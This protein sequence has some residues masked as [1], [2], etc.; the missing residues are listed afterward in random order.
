MNSPYLATIDRFNSLNVMVIGDAMLDVY[1]NGSANRICREAPVPIVDIKDVRTLPGGAA[2]TAVNLAELGARVH[3]LSIMGCDHEAELLKDSL[4]SHGLDTSLIMRDRARRTITKQ[5]VAAGNQ[6]LVRFD[7]GT[8]EA[9]RGGY[10]R[11]LINSLKEKFHEVDAVVVSDYGYG[12]MTDKVIGVLGALQRKK[13]NILVIDAKSLDKY[14]RI[15][16]TVAK[17]N[18]QEL[19][20][21]LAITEPAATGY[22]SEQIK[23]YGQKLLKKTGTRYVAA[24]IDIEGALLFQH[25]KEPYRTFSKPVENTRAAGA[26]DTYVS[27]L[28]LALAAGASIEAAAE[29]AKSAAVVILQKSATATCTQNELSHYFGSSSKYIPDWKELK[30]RFDT[31]RKEGRR[32]V[33]TNGCF[34]LLHSGHVTY[35]EQARALGDVLVLGLN[36]D[37]SIKRL[38]GSNRPINNLYERIRILSGLESVTLMTSFEEDTPISL[39][40]I[41]RPD[42]YVKGGD[43]NIENLPEAPIV[44]AY[45]GKVQIMPFVQDRSTTKIITRIK[46][47]DKQ[48]A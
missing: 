14:V 32:I 17:P 16:A 38:K 12:V 3:Y 33:F 29:I 36:S 21:L 28:T 34:D 1:L 46:S 9:I 25:G 39:L 45:G 4:E 5:R 37:T 27:A 48:P 42:M 22:R 8:T 6:L 41:I 18:Y 7:T 31:F 15:G 2:N 11:Q 26:G 24:T 19:V 13:E 23:R 30:S 43:Y 44:L 20:T 47:L 35:L 10:E 40:A